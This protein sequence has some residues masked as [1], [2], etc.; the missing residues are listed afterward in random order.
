MIVAATIV[1]IIVFLLSYVFYRNKRNGLD[2]LGGQYLG[3]GLSKSAIKKVNASVAQLKKPVAQLKKIDK[4]AR[5]KAAR[6]KAARDKAAREK[7]AR[8]AVT[9]AAKDPCEW[10][11][12]LKKS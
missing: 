12:H 7:A 4:A 6:E 11:K 3:L 1:T 2:D 8:E 9:K 5:E 10:V